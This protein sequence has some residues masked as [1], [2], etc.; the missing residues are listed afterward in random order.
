MFLTDLNGNQIYRIKSDGHEIG[1]FGAG[2]HQQVRDHCNQAAVLFEV[3]G[4]IKENGMR[5]N[6]AR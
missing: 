6:A 3:R 2:G 1:P 4:W 5:F